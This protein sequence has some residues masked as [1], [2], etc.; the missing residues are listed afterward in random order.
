M[1]TPIFQISPNGR[2][3]IKGRNDLKYFTY[4]VFSQSI[5]VLKDGIFTG[6]EHPGNI[7]AFLQ[8]HKKTVRVSARDHFK[9]LS[10][11]DH[12]AWQMTRHVSRNLEAHYFSFNNKMAAYHTEKIKRAI[13][14][15]PCFD[16]L[17]DCKKSAESILKYTW[18]GE[19]HITL[20]PHGLLEFNRGIHAKLIYVDDPF[21]DPANKLNLTLIKKIN[22]I[23]LTQI[24]DMAQDEIHIAGTPQTDQDFFFDEE[25]LHDFARLIQPAISDEARKI[26]LWPEWKDW[27]DL[28]AILKNKGR[29]RFNQEYQCRPAYS[30][31]SYI[32]PDEYD[33]C[34][35]SSLV[36]YDFRTW[37]KEIKRREKAKEDTQTD[38]IAGFD[39]GKKR[40]PSKLVIFEKVKNVWIQRHFKF[41]DHWD[42]KDQ[43]VYLEQAIDIFGIDYLFYDSTRGEFEGFAEA[44]QLPGE[45][46]GVNFTF[47]RKNAMAVAMDKNITNQTIQFIADD[48]QRN[49]MLVVDSD[50]NAVETPEG[51]G[52][53]F[54]ATGLIFAEVGDDEEEEEEPEKPE[55]KHKDDNWED[56]DE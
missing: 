34:V 4:N 1:T 14:S 53:S 20:E 41:M 15:N 42:Y 5:A 35:N 33:K 28:Q 50:L 38:R 19:H 39:I 22:D 29:R 7:S 44:G 45:M 23:V 13:A 17:V 27:D 40:H 18:D 2:H 26:V 52:E 12:F 8:N 36:N 31:D 51:H 48:R 56:D 9:S 54:F 24:L 55:R 25:A 43:L 46:I 37:E 30:E 6:G 21:Q 11:Y 16:E 32:E 47:K 10:F 49:Q 3:L